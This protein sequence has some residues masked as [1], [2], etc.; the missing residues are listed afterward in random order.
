MCFV[1]HGCGI[2]QPAHPTTEPPTT[3]P[4][5]APAPPISGIDLTCADEVIHISFFGD[6]KQ[7][8][9]TLEVYSQDLGSL[10]SFFSQDTLESVTMNL[11]DAPEQVQQDLLLSLSNIAA[12]KVSLGIQGS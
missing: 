5:T 3:T 9:E 7:Y 12:P 8:L 4:T 6:N 10:N 11:T 2:Q 1:L